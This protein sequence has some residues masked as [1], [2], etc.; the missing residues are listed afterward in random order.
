MSPPCV[1]QIESNNKGESFNLTLAKGKVSDSI[2]QFIPYKKRKFHFI[3]DEQSSSSS[4]SSIQSETQ[5][6]EC[7]S[8]KESELG[9]KIDNESVARPDPKSS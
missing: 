2:R 7:I 3:D 9:V 1:N 8:E 6:N 5:L 4:L